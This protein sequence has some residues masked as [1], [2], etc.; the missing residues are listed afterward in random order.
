MTG[1][2][3]TE[4]YKDEE[5][6]QDLLTFAKSTQNQTNTITVNSTLPISK[7]DIGY[8]IWGGRDESLSWRKHNSKAR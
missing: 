7:L 6:V 8:A 1:D 3:E 2:S 4:T 5:W